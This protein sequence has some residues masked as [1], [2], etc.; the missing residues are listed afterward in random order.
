MALTSGIGCRRTS[1]QHRTFMFLRAG[2]RLTYYCKLCLITYYSLL[3]CYACFNFLY[4][5]SVLLLHLIIFIHLF[6]YFILLFLFY[7]QCFH[8]GSRLPRERGSVGCECRCALQLALGW[9]WRSQPY[10]FLVPQVGALNAAVNVLLP[11]H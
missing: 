1:E 10:L 11:V 7:L 2:L 9:R 3:N 6:L 5:I 8:R 4:F